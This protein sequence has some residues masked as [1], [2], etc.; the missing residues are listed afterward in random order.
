LKQLQIKSLHVAALYQSFEINETDAEQEVLQC[1]APATVRRQCYSV[2]RRQGTFKEYRKRQIIFAQGKPADE[3][4]FIQRGE[5]KLSVRSKR[6]K[7]AVIAMLGPGD[8]LGEGCLNGQTSRFGTAKAMTDC[9]A[10]QLPKEATLEAL[11]SDPRFGEFFIAY[12]L[13]RNLRVEEDLVDHLFNSAEKRLARL[14]LLL[15]NF[16]K[17]DRKE[18]IIAN[19]SQETLAEMVGT[20]RSRVSFFMNRFRK[21]GF[22]SY[23]GGLEIHTSLLNIVLRE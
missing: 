22:I 3:L 19:I 20:T 14:L 2:N 4:Y 5:I 8:F 23:D 7:E 18:Q 15:A 9:S 10:L 6:G 1:R 21:L 13:S 11:H 16:G 17:D 12:L